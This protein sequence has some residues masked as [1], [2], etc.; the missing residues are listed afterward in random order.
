MFARAYLAR[1]L[2]L[3]GVYIFQT[4]GIYGFL[5]WVPTL[6]AD[7]GFKLSNSLFSVTMMD[8]GAPIGALIAALISDRWER[9][10]MITITALVIAF[11]GVMYGLS[12]RMAV[13]VIFGTDA[14]NNVRILYGGSVKSDNAKSLQAQPEIDGFLI[15]GASLDPVSFAEIVNLYI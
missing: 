5:A 4:L 14:A 1:T 12:S 15:G 13:I 2:M 9:K 3:I 10:Y 6:L 8:I 7:H 11:F